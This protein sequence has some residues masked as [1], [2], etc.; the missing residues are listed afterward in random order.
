MNRILET[1]L[2][3]VVATLGFSSLYQDILGKE[4]Y[5][6]MVDAGWLSGYYTVPLALLCILAGLGTLS[7]QNKKEKGIHR[8]FGRREDERCSKENGR[9]SRIR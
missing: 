5:L 6:K 1:F 3:G 2:A 9:G 7:I 8:D 4:A